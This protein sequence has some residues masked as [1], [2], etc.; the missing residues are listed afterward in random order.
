MS[1]F[2]T[3]DQLP[4][5][6][7]LP[8]PFRLNDG[9]RVRTGE[10]WPRRRAELTA[11]ILYYAYGR[12]PGPPGNVV[13]KETAST[14]DGACG[15][16][17]KKIALTMG[18]GDAIRLNLEAV[19]P[20][21]KG[22]FPVIITGDLCW[23]R[24][25][26]D[27][28]RRVVSRGYILV[29]FDRTEIVPDCDDGRAAAAY[30]LYPDCD[31]G[32]LAAWAWGY[33]R[34]VD[35]LVGTDF[36]DRARIGITGHS[37]GGKA[38]LLAGALDERIG[39]VAPNNS[40][41][42]GAGCYRHQAAGSEDLGAITTNFPY[43]WGPRLKE[44]VGRVDRLPFDQDSL[45]ALVAPRALLTTEALG[46]LWANPEGTQVTHLAARRV[47]EFLGAADKIGIYFRPGS[48]EQNIGDWEVLLDFAD[49]QMLGKPVA[50]RFDKLG[51]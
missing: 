19:I 44:F 15:A 33:H 30:R 12:L 41:C 11:A 42:G 4:S 49:R 6:K 26:A 21:G 45:K 3:A 48:H 7:E 50:R 20:A 31:W 40:G 25:T 5:V 35:Y 34:V 38:A 22:P 23:H 13:G 8:D 36:A 1:K 28:L 47:F 51:F 14:V 32:A 39:L 37:R 17:H 9:R 18:P 43:W 10:D 24:I 16:I 46:D 2:P 29:Q 27:L